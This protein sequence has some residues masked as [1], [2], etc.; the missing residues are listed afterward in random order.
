MRDKDR[1]VEKAYAEPRRRTAAA[2]TRREA[3]CLLNL[4][5]A[6]K[7]GRCG[8]GC[9]TKVK[10][11]KLNL[12]RNK[13]LMAEILQFS[14][15]R[16]QTEIAQTLKNQQPSQSTVVNRQKDASHDPS[17]K[18]SSEAAS[19]RSHQCARTAG[20]NSEPKQAAQLL[21]ICRHAVLIVRSIFACFTFFRHRCGRLFYSYS[22]FEHLSHHAY[23][24]Q[25]R[26]FLCHR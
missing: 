18:E 12:P 14:A 23:I 5:V 8:G 22:Y 26:S 6:G 20:T 11:K 24:H 19:G 2:T 9:A 21:Q 1:L 4:I 15:S 7:N 16:R 17:E 13:M 3:A 25:I 10:G